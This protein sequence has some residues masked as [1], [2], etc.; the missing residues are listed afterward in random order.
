MRNKIVVSVGMTNIAHSA[1]ASELSK[2]GGAMNIHCS[3]QEAFA[4]LAWLGLA[5]IVIEQERCL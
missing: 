4:P 1:F 2:K 5:R 3:W